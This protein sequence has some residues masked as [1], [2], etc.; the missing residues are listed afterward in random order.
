MSSPSRV[1]GKVEETPALAPGAT[2]FQ[3]AGIGQPGQELSGGNLAE[4]G[5]VG[6]LGGRDTSPGPAPVR[7]VRFTPLE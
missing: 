3:M 1:D 7:N 4:S 2:P 6:N 5:Q